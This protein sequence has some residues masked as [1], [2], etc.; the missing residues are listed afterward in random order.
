MNALNM[1]TD[2]SD[3]REEARSVSGTTEAQDGASQASDVSSERMERLERL[4]VMIADQQAQFMA[5]Q[6]KIEDQLSRQDETKPTPSSE[7]SFNGPV[8]SRT[9]S[10]GTTVACEEDRLP[11]NANRHVDCTSARAAALLTAATKGAT[12]L[13]AAFRSIGRL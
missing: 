6:F 11:S 9:S 1:V 13:S 8:H 4:L 10:D 7:H 3:M 2:P 12:N 5:N